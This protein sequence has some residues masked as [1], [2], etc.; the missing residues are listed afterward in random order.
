VLEVPTGGVEVVEA[1]MM[2]QGTIFNFSA[3]Y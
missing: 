3:N 1:M 2:A